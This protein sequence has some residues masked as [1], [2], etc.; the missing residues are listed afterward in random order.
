MSEVEEAT[1]GAALQ[2]REGHHGKRIDGGAEN[3]SKKDMR[4]IESC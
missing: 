1:S 4:A 2:A 3:E